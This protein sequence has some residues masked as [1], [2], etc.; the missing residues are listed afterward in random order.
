[1]GAGEAAGV[2]GYGPAGTAGSWRM[3]RRRCPEV[4]G[5]GEIE[6]AG[7][8]G[9]GGTKTSSGGTGELAKRIAERRCKDCGRLGAWGREYR[10]MRDSE[11]E[12]FLR[13]SRP[14]FQ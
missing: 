3:C 14:R 1:M 8:G 2:A 6:T 4:W 10:K 11:L 9:D 12:S 13:V 7:C 5:S